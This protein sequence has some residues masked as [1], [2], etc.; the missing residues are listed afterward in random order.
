MPPGLEASSSC[1]LRRNSRKASLVAKSGSPGADD[2]AISACDAPR[3][4]NCSV[5]PSSASLHGLDHE[6]HAGAAEGLL[7]RKNCSRKQ[8]REEPLIGKVSLCRR[9]GDGDAVHVKQLGP[10]NSLRSRGSGIVA[11]V[12]VPEPTP[13]RCS[14]WT[15]H[16]QIPSFLACSAVAMNPKACLHRSSRGIPSPCSL[17]SATTKRYPA[18][19]SP[20]ETTSEFQDCRRGG[21]HG[22]RDPQTS[23]RPSAH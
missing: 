2:P 14:A 9:P 13:R 3:R 22:E 20:S 15:Q 12:K 4:T 16:E 10:S 1:L 11:L 21:L 17:C 18:A 23:A 19:P 6:R 5:P 7:T 8:L